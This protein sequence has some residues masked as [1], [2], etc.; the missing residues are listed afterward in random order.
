MKTK[1]A[2][3]NS[4]MSYLLGLLDSINKLIFKNNSV[5]PYIHQ[6][7][8]DIT[9]VKR[10]IFHEN[11]LFILNQKKKKEKKKRMKQNCQSIYNI[12]KKSPLYSFKSLARHAVLLISTFIIDT[13]NTTLQFNPTS[14]SFLYS[15]NTE[16]LPLTP[17]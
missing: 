2:S 14:I 12:P 6:L 4:N 15:P 1:F 10:K 17:V 16:T 9:I 8:V 3:K 13:P 5:A 7:I 11:S